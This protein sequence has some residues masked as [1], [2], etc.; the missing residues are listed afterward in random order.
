MALVGRLNWDI[1]EELDVIDKSLEIWG[2]EKFAAIERCIR[3][4]ISNLCRVA[5]VKK[6]V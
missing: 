1:W 2:S 3:Y 5:Q 6:K 4:I